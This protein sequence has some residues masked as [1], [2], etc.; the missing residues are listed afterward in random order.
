MQEGK[1]FKDVLLR[2]DTHIPYEKE[3]KLQKFAD[4]KD[5]MCI[6]ENYSLLID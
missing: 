5:I 6:V 4:W 3:L 2:I 1:I